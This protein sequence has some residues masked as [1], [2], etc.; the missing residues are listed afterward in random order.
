MD[1]AAK[2]TSKRIISLPVVIAAGVLVI[3]A[4]VLVFVKP[5]ATVTIYPKT[6]TV[7][8]EM[9][10]SGR[11]DISSSNVDKAI[12]PL[13]RLSVE[14]TVTKNFP[15]SGNRDVVS[16]AH[17][18]ITVYNNF[19]SA[20]QAI[21]ATT[22]FLSASG[23]IFRTPVPLIIPG[24]HVDQGKKVPGSIEVEVIADG[25]GEAYN[26]LPSRFTIPG[27]AGTPKEK[28][29][30]AVSQSPMTGGF[31]GQS[32]VVE[33][34]DIDDAKASIIP[35]GKTRLEDA[36]RK[37]FPPDLHFIDG[38]LT[39][40]TSE[41][42]TNPAAGEPG[43]TFTLRVHTV[44]QALLFREQD[45]LSILEPN[46]A[47][48]LASQFVTLPDTRKITYT[49]KQFDSTVGRLAFT[50][51][52]SVKTQVVVGEKELAGK[53]AGMDIHQTKSF[54]TQENQIERADL[55]LWPFW[56]RHLPKDPTRIKVI[57]G[58]K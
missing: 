10:M 28:A 32:H 14:D 48:H 45:V 46:I 43:D 17:G 3:A 49:V 58:K 24:T 15:S 53:M 20:S 30:Y 23:K 54:F 39:V 55:S 42:S 27:F 51:L 12:I 4:T 7:E 41:I 37:K 19:S 31:K 33:Q 5:S 40:S 16:K 21:V 22:R 56:A 2:T 26:I 9:D 57:M 36:L 50:V 47:A 29:F 13:E 8:F 11:T 34:K 1:A 44:A 6:E 35:S 52:V 25:A 18:K 38:A